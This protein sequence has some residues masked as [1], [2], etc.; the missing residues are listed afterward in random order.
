MTVGYSVSPS[1]CRTCR[2]R[3]RHRIDTLG[4]TRC[5]ECPDEVCAAKQAETESA[6]EE[7]PII[8]H[9][10][11]GGTLDTFKSPIGVAIIHEMT[12]GEMIAELLAFSAAKMEGLSIDELRLAIART[13]THTTRN[14]IYA[15]AG[16]SEPN[17]WGW[18]FE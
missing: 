11:F 15:E 1:S 12:K 9:T 13:R 10:L 3:A 18:L 17:M 5:E 6:T 14:A 16:V 2:H 7:A 4:K 8:R